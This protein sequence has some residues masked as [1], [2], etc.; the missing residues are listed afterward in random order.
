ME[1]WY[2]SVCNLVFSKLIFLLFATVR[3]LSQGLSA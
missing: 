3:Q 2:K 1:F